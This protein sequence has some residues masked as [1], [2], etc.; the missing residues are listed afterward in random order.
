MR[1]LNFNGLVESRFRDLLPMGFALARSEKTLVVYT[2]GAL[3]VEIYHGRASYEIGLNL[4]IGEARYSLGEVLRAI[5][6]PAGEAY[7]NASGTDQASIEKAVD[8][9]GDLLFQSIVPSLS[10]QLALSAVLEQCRADWARGYALQVLAE[11][12]RPLAE[13]AFRDR[14]FSRAAKLY[15]QISDALSEAEVRKYLYAKARSE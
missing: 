2:S 8:Q 10:D 12:I 5:G 13:Q 9:L 15:S 3:S 14:D 6:D 1:T 4:V 7:R 11:N